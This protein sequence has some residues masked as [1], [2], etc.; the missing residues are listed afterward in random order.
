[1]TLKIVFAGTPL[2]AAN[3]LNTLLESEHSVIALYTQV[4][5][6][7][8]R[9]RKLEE[10]LVK[11][12]AK[13]HHVPVFQPLSLKDPN[14][15]AALQNLN[16]DLMIVAA[17]GMILPKAVLKIPKFGC[18]NVHFSLL[19]RYRGAAPIQHTILAGDTTTGITIMQMDESLDTGDILGLFP[20]PI[21]PRDTTASLSE[22]LSTLAQTALLETLKNLED[23]K[24]HPLKQNEDNV[25]YAP[26]ISKQDA[27]LEWNNTALVLDRQ[28]RAYNPWPVAFTQL[29]NDTVRIWE[30][31]P[32]DKV[33]HKA[34]PGTILETK[35]EGI[36]V[37]T[38]K[39]ILRLLVLQFPGGKPLSVSNLLNAKRAALQ[40]GTQFT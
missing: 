30:A 2:L 33:T 39:G 31:M 25:S 18:I 13:K 1:M 12:I 20:C 7:R 4:D 21:N 32:L 14:V 15:Q 29:Q 10:N 37:A 38:Q 35:T 28:I 5:K 11:T 36:D 23:K 24:L 17:Y 34:A 6:P 22:R 19:P 9:G 3:I 16:P 8:G 27:K 26:K 40:P